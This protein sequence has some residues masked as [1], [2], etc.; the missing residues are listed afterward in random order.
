MKTHLHVHRNTPISMKE[1]T[2]ARKSASQGKKNIILMFLD[3]HKLYVLRANH[4]F[5][6]IVKEIFISV[7]LKTKC[8]V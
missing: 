7:V 4:E 2:L 5:L 8:K 6:F 3:K 1:K